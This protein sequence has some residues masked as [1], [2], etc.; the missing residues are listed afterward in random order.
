M[1][2]NQGRDRRDEL[3]R[4]LGLSRRERVVYLYIGRYGQDDLDWSR[5]GR[6]RRRGIHFVAYDP[7]PG[8][9]PTNL[10]VIPRPTGR[11]AS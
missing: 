5:L 9:G 1:V 3:V 4:E 7:A 8:G 6:L 2:V 11:A 10:H